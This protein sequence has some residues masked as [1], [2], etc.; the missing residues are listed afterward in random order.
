[1]RLVA[2]FSSCSQIL[3]V[4]YGAQQVP[5][6]IFMK[7]VHLTGSNIVSF[8]KKIYALLNRRRGLAI[9]LFEILTRELPT[10]VKCFKIF[11]CQ[12]SKVEVILN[13]PN[14]SKM[15]VTLTVH[16]SPNYIL[17]YEWRRVLISP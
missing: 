15:I 2:N 5:P 3:S 6:R 7:F 12:S 11:P 4:C 16:E 1:M 8:W 10:N 9:L 13:S 17:N 14:T